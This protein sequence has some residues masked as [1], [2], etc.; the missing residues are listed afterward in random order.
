MRKPQ[1]PKSVASAFCGM[2]HR[3]RDGAPLAHRCHML[4]PPKHFTNAGVEN[5]AKAALILARGGRM[6]TAQG[7]RWSV[8]RTPPIDPPP[9]LPDEL[10]RL[11]RN[12]PRGA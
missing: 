8:A 5:S 3:F 12:A 2:P 11:Q 7:T 10:L 1:A 6:W 4:P 9:D